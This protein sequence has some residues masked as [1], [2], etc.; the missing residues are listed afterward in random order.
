MKKLGFTL[1]LVM[2]SFVGFSQNFSVGPK[3]GMSSSKL[4]LKEKN[5]VG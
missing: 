2:I 5:Y 3:I 4:D 1:A